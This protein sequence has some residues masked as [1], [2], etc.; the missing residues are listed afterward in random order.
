MKYLTNDVIK[1]AYRSIVI[2]ILLCISLCLVSCCDYEDPQC[3]IVLG[4]HNN[5]KNIVMSLTENNSDKLIEDTYSQF[6]KVMV[7]NSEGDAPIIFDSDIHTQLNSD[8]S[9]EAHKDGRDYW[10]EN[11]LNLAVETTKE[12]INNYSPES[13]ETNLLESLYKA[14]KEFDKSIYNKKLIICDTGLSTCGAVSF[15]NEDWYTLLYD[16]N[17]NKLDSLCK[18]LAD[19]Y[20]LPDLT[21]VEITW[22][23]LGEV[24]GDQAIDKRRKENLRRIWT[25]I[26]ECSAGDT[27]KQDGNSVKV[28]NSQTDCSINFVDKNYDDVTKYNSTTVT[29][30]IFGSENGHAEIPI[31]AV[32]FNPNN[33]VFK[34]KSESILDLK[35]IVNYISV[36]EEKVLIVGCTHNDGIDI[37]GEAERISTER[38]RAVVDIL[39]N[40]YQINPSRIEIYSA[41]SDAYWTIPGNTK[42][43]GELNRIALVIP[44]SSGYS[45]EIRNNPDKYR[46]I[47]NN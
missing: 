36:Q 7:I 30:I 11:Y 21:G 35:P 10:R 44:E 4:K 17:E 25:K 5:S 18:E 31:C 28:D 16:F 14:G 8:E 23:G 32:D 9:I 20:E 40:D 33:A 1:I 37:A 47:S 45:R 39:I 38:V 24:G 42:E 46:P 34:N 15:L 3:V 29:T 19:N 43:N 22:Y 26:L 27:I 2:G 13:D 12:V 41:E 6:G